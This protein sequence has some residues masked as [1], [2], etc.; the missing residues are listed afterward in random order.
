[1]ADREARLAQLSPAKRELLRRKLE[2]SKGAGDAIRPLTAGATRTLSFAQERFWFLSR[3]E[4]RSTEYTLIGGG[5]LRGPLDL[6]AL[7]SALRALARRHEPLR[8]RFPAS[9]GVPVVQVDPTPGEILGLVDLGSDRG[10]DADAVIA[11]ELEALRELPFDLENGPLLRARLVR[12]GD[13]DHALLLSYHHILIDGWSGAILRRDL[14][15]LYD[16]SVRD[17]AS[18][19][20][21]LAIAYTDYAAW[22]RERLSGNRL[23]ALVEHWRVALQGAPA[24]LPLPTDRARPALLSHAG[25][26]APVELS[27]EL[28]ARLDALAAREGVT[29]FV[30]LLGAF[31]AFLARISGETDVVVGT[32]FAN[33]E[34]R[35]VQ[36]LIGVFVNTLALRTDCSGSPDFS[37]LVRRAR[38]TT[39]E[40]LAHGELPFEK[41]VA[42]LSPDRDP[43][44]TPLFNVF[45]EMPVPVPERGMEGLLVARIPVPSGRALFDLALS[46]EAVDG[47]YEGELQYNLDLFDGG[48]VER[49]ARAFERFVDGVVAEPSRPV[50]RVP[51]LGEGEREALLPGLVGVRL[52]VDFAAVHEEFEAAAGR[53]PHAAALVSADGIVEYGALDARADALARL[54]RGD[55]VRNGAVVGVY[56]PRSVD[57]VVA[58]LAVWKAGG[59][60]LPLDPEDPPRRT[61]FALTD[62]GAGTVVTSKELRARLPEGGW[63]TRCVDDADGV[64][65]TLDGERTSPSDPAYVI[66]TSGSTG[67][68]KGV[69]VPHGALANHVAW[70]RASFGFETRDRFLLRTPTAFDASLWEIVHPLANGA[71]LVVAPPGAERDARALIELAAD[72]GVTVLQGV[73][74]LVRF[75]LEEPDFARCRELRH[76]VVGGEALPVPLV[77]KFERLRD[78]ERLGVTLHNL[79]GPTEAAIDSASWS[80]A[81]D[82]HLA[83]TRER[84][85][86]GGP[87]AN[88]SLHVLDAHGEPVPEGFTGELHVSGSN[89]AL[90]YVNRP[91]LDEAC[92][93]RD[94]IGERTYRTGDLVRRAGGG[95]LEFVG[96]ADSQVKLKG[97][98]I[99]LEEIESVIA[100]HPGVSAAAA[101]VHRTAGG[102]PRLVGYVV[103]AGEIDELGP[104]LSERLPAPM[105]PSVF[106]QLETLPRTRSEKLDRN[107]LLPPPEREETRARA[108]TPLEREIAV[109]VAELLGLAP[110]HVGRDDDFFALGGHSLFATRLLA[111]IVERF[112]VEIPLLAFFERPTVGGLADRVSS[113]EH[114]VT[115]IPRT[116]RGARI[117]LSFA[118]E[119]LWFL[120]RLAG[121]STE[122]DM[123]GALRLKGDLDRAALEQSLD[124]LFERHELL[125]TV[126]PSEDGVP[127]QEILPHAR[128]ALVATEHETEDHRARDSVLREC[129]EEESRHVFDLERGPLVRV[130]LLRFA[131]DDHALIFNQHHILSDGISVDVLTGELAELYAARVAGREPT[132]L[133]VELAFAD[134][135]AWERGRDEHLAS[136]L[137]HWKATLAGSPAGLPLPTDFARPAQKAHAGGAVGFELGGELTRELRALAARTAVTPFVVMCALYQAYLSR[138]TGE[139]DVV[140][141]TPYANRER[142]EVQRMLGAFVNTLPLRSNLSGAPALEELLGRV[143]AT[144]QSALAHGELPFERM[145]QEL[146][147]VR[148]PSRTPLFNAF[149]ELRTETEL[150]AW[151]GLD[152][153][154]VDETATPALFDLSLSVGVSGESWSGVFHFD[155]ALFEASTIERLAAGFT[156]FVAGC[157]ASPELA[158]D[159]VPLVGTEERT[160]TLREAEGPLLPFD[161]SLRVHHRFEERA[162]QA[163]EA[164][165]LVD[166]AGTLTYGALDARANGLAHELRGRG[167]RRGTVVGVWLPRSSDSV[168]TLLAIWKAGGVCLPLDP[169]DPESRIDLVLRSSGAELVV[170]TSALRERLTRGSFDVLELGPNDPV[171]STDPAAPA[172][173]EPADPAYLVYTSGT[174]GEPK[175]V[176][177]SHG[178]L[179]NNL[180][181]ARAAFGFGARDRFLFRTPLSFDAALWELVHP[182]ANGASLV[183]A[184]PGT[185]RDASALLDLAA[186]SGVTVLQAVPTLLAYWLDEPAFARCRE[187]R[188]LVCGGEALTPALLGRFARVRDAHALDLA[189]HNVYGPA[190]AT[191]DTSAWTLAPGAPVD[192]TR[193]RVPIGRAIANAAVYVLDRHGEPVPRGATGELYIGGP[194]VA[195]GYVGRDDLTALSFRANPFG[196]GR[197]YRTGDLGRRAADGELEFVGRVDSQV[198]LRGH[199]IE[200]EEVE[201]VL[202]EA[203]GVERAAVALRE[204]PGQGGRLVGYYVAGAELDATDLA[205][206]LEARLPR[207]MV[208]GSFVRLDALPLTASEKID[209]SALPDPP[210]E[211]ST[212]APPRTPTEAALVEL[213]GELFGL[214]R[215]GRDDDLFSLGAH[216]LLLTRLAA[217]VG[218]RFGVEL[219]LLAFFE[220]PTVA[221]I[222][223]AVDDA[224]PGSAT[225]IV[226]VT[227]GGPLPVSFSQERLWFLDRLAGGSAEYNL[228]GALRLR[229]ALD[230][231]ALERSV[232]RVFARHE[233]LRTVFPER[234]GVPT[235]RILPSARFAL[236]CEEVGGLAPSERDAI[237]RARLELEARHVFDLAHGPLV[238][239]RLLRFDAEDHAFLVNQHHILSDGVSVALL[240]EE[241]AELY[242]AEL[243][244]ETADL[245]PLAV[246]FADFA[247]WERATFEPDSHLEYWREALRGAPPETSIPSDRPRPSVQSRAGAARAFSLSREL[248]DDLC[249]LARERGSSVFVTLLAGFVALLHRTTGR[250]DLVVGTAVANRTHPETTGM[251]GFFA[252]AVPLRADASGGPSFAELLDR[253]RRSVHGALGHQSLSFE[254]L[255]EELNPLRDLARAPLFQISFDLVGHGRSEPV[256]AGLVVEEV[257]SATET[258]KLDLSVFVDASGPELTA[259][260]EY[261]TALYDAATIDGLWERYEALLASAVETPE[262]G[263]AGLR[264]GDPTLEP[265]RPVPFDEREAPHVVVERRARECPD[266]VALTWVAPTPGHWTRGELDARARGLAV[267]LR[268]RGIGRES[269]VALCLDR[270]PRLY[271]ALLGVWKAG[272]AWFP[273]DATDPPAV[274][275]DRLRDAEVALVIAE[276]RFHAELAALGVPVWGAD[277]RSDNGGDQLPAVEPDDLAYVIPTSGSTGRPKLVEVPFRAL[278]NHTAWVDRTLRLGPD[279]AVLQRIPLG[280]D[281]ALLEILAPLCGGARLVVVPDEDDRDPRALFELA[282]RENVTSFLSV[283]SMTAAILDLGRMEEWS[284]LRQVVVGGERMDPGLPERMF[285]TADA[286]GRELEVFNL[287]GPAEACIDATAHRCRRN[288]A[289]EVPIGR[290]ISNVTVV[291]R[292]AEGHAVPAGVVGELYI[293]GAGLARGYRGRPDW[294]AERFVAEAGGARSYRTGDL[295]RRRS[296]GA[297]VFAGR[298]DLQVQVRGRRVE[299]GEIEAVLTEHPT[300]R[301]AAVTAATDRSGDTQLVAHVVGQV[302]LAELRRHA[303]ARLP[304]ALRPGAWRVLDALPRTRNGK[305]DRRALEAATANTPRVQDLVGVAEAPIGEVESELCRLFAQTLEREAVG[306]RDDFFALGGTSLSAVR[307]NRAVEQA[308]EVELPLRALFES[309]TP[310]DFGRALTHV[311]DGGDVADVLHGEDVDLFAEARLDA[312]IRPAP[313]A[314]LPSRPPRKVLLTG[315]TGYLGAFVLR[316]LL[317][318]TD[319]R[320][321]CLVRAKDEPAAT[322]RLARNLARYEIDHDESRVVVVVGDLAAPELGLDE[323]ARSALAD[324]LDLVVHGG[325]AVNFL[326]GYRALAP[327]NV[328]G[329]RSLLR[330]A[331]LAGRVPFHFVSSVGVLTGGDHAPGEGVLEDVDLDGLSGCEGGYDRTKWVAEKLVLEAGARGLPVSIHRPGRVAGDSRSGLSNP[332]D[333]AGRV[334]QACLELGCAPDL[335]VAMDVTPVDYVSAALVH[336]AVRG[337]PGGGPYH[338]VSSKRTQFSEMLGWAED[339]GYALERV[340]LEEWYERLGARVS[341]DPGDGLAAL[342]PLVAPE[343]TGTPRASDFIGDVRLPR[344]DDRRSR[345]GLRGSGVACPEV[346]AALFARWIERSRETRKTSKEHGS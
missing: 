85:P 179:A 167:V 44:R 182:L 117:P 345:E 134:Y 162:R 256:W 327:P 210:G 302:D 330:L 344:I 206:H 75:W 212:S 225:A 289:G 207:Y 217:R 278:A 283:H 272:A 268:A 100:E 18:E 36:D 17:E 312:D 218:E 214:G 331:C 123:P 184:S 110:E 177:V 26:A 124:A 339:L 19:L 7:R 24:S 341:A 49:L 227:R 12:L 3:L 125:R 321:H 150:P 222:G 1:M 170:S 323:S 254:R 114:G 2:R 41:L 46:L 253:V 284:T 76:L 192:T 37:E 169:E 296:D 260:I 317:E 221:A 107:A 122:Y 303:G 186:S 161:A 271:E 299:P 213:V 68:P 219:P 202:A 137:A 50:D 43:S 13:D 191:I 15:A 77:R 139:T 59:V 23:A 173:E 138:L 105:V 265:E 172:V 164:T 91:E 204:S 196:A 40:A 128:F 29:S 21:E 60:Y 98:R 306:R 203:Q 120:H 228:A 340:P 6:A 104:F 62:S 71:A 230:R 99:E 279:D 255:V 152:V 72:R 79:Y 226:P 14:C 200:L 270:T 51:L 176:G 324:S 243:R 126:F 258:A 109:L 248:S 305:V 56:L 273:L 208:P 30:A 282:L 121:G 81:P 311:L 53:E 16:A 112:G 92:F 141:G 185:E 187:L 10:A 318:H 61:G 147:P 332:D 83:R 5:R 343:H 25:G 69:V 342:M 280:F 220:A 320:I 39:R 133:P 287:Y 66:Y 293:G 288:E 298:A 297:L 174:T 90:S 67:V 143:A 48:T 233:V 11:R 159:R 160:R 163:P 269:L 96:R 4:P 231:G 325:A 166:D 157:L 294:T 301:D 64:T 74:T 131:A 251:L 244:G 259:E 84:V 337:A 38:A 108:R 285:A 247:T 27:P 335:Q 111:R 322:E 235:Q 314:A 103:P 82:E 199:R 238:R 292:D 209:R 275:R 34:R 304:A 65:G 47:T 250:D 145:I 201:A 119:R 224:E 95:E 52:E 313:G 310:A 171:G 80:L 242:S 189:L 252:N 33:R 149:F 234:D 86:I 168:V 127:R 183:V 274:R 55:G 28:S 240:T 9:A 57:T 316:E 307:L 54:L 205:S 136:L 338:L 118:Q 8:T 178:A 319:A 22:Q 329:T 333:V 194:G 148:D 42:E 237:L 328:E 144:A 73:P 129:L 309:P 165:A 249:A 135:A 190:E 197:L 346:D 158:F 257:P 216:S 181:W 130:G 116:S 31:Q 32:P 146:D 113:G 300:V 156:R 276:P 223:R 264:L 151:P 89:L 239:M 142:P 195:L 193:E 87:I 295:A 267:S 291:L 211:G 334:M 261:G 102:E 70:G 154:P 58:L 35:E 277:D 326:E 241:L 308:F 232:V 229:G 153:V 45:F 198:K 215:F 94:P 175:G 63:R 245:E 188:H 140:V 20:P 263:V 315:A 281:A 155:V 290:P 236:D 132:L 115:P 180:A 78:E 88:V 336:L 266:A 97:N 246:Q 93:V 286:A 106:V 101:R 262:R